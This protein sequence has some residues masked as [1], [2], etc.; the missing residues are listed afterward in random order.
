MCLGGESVRANRGGAQAGKGS[1]DETLYM[2]FF[3]S[4]NFGNHFVKRNS[5]FWLFFGV[6]VNG[7]I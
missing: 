6:K 5:P 4:Y 2:T 1:I 7:A 3:V